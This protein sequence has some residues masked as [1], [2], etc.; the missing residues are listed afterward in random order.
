LKLTR[1]RPRFEPRYA[2]FS[3]FW[4]FSR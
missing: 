2:N 3:E 1:L 4:P